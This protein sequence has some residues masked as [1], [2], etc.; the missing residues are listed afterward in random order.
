MPLFLCK[1]R[2]IDGDSIDLFF[3]TDTVEEAIELFIEAW[4]DVSWG[5]ASIWVYTLPNPGENVGMLDWGLIPRIE[6]PIPRR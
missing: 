6:V 4:Q 5:R 3:D 1:A 2:D